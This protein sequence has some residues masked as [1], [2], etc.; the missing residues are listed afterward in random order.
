MMKKY[1]LT[2]SLSAPDGVTPDLAAAEVC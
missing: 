1:L 2:L